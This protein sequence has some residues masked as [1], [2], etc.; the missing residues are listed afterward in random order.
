M[1]FLENFS[2][3]KNGKF[4]V[5]TLHKNKS[6]KDVIKKIGLSFYEENNKL[7][8]YDKNFK[9]VEIERIFL[10]DIVIKNDHYIIAKNIIDNYTT[11]EVF[12]KRGKFL[13]SKVIKI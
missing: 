11:I 4:N 3:E 9:S 2:Q 13:K 1:Y 8:A 12:N 7:T 6:V 5:P 10:K